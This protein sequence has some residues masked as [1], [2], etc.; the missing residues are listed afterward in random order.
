MR[1]I[2]RDRHLPGA[3]AVLGDP[4]V[5]EAL[6]DPALDFWAWSRRAWS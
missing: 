2:L 4:D 3:A 1:S 5:V 6:A